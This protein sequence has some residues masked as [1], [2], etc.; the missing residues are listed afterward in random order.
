M[1]HLQVRYEGASTRLPGLLAEL[2]SGDTEVR[3]TGAEFGASAYLE[4]PHSHHRALPSASSVRVRTI[5]VD[6][7]DPSD[8]LAR[9]EMTLSSPESRFLLVLVRVGSRRPEDVLFG[10]GT[11]L[12]R[13]HAVP[14]SR[15]G[16]DA[17]QADSLFVAWVFRSVPPPEAFGR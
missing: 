16:V 8:T 5:L 6:P 14:L 3:L 1:L 15:V 11:P 7:A 10:A 13:V 4:T 9:H 17:T 12:P 2:R